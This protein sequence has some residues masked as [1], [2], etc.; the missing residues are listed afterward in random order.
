[1]L[2]R[3][4][5]HTFIP[6]LLPGNPVVIDLGANK[7][8]FSLPMQKRGCRVLAIEPVPELAAALRT[9]GVTV[10]E[11]A[12]TGSGGESIELT[13][14]LGRDA[15]M[16]GSVM[17]LG[18]VGKMLTESSTR[19]TVRVP[20]M[21]LEGAI[22]RAAGADLVKVDIEGAELDVLL[23]A[24]PET[25]LRIGQLAVEFHDFWYEQL[26][27]RTEQVKRRLQGLGF[28]MIRFTPNNK[29]VLFVNPR[30]RLSPLKRFW[31]AHVLRNVNG[32]G[33][34]MLIVLRRLG[35]MAQPASA[36]PRPTRQPTS[37]T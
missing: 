18:V 5:Q 13:Y 26:V 11:A 17:G 31:I 36:T 7:G 8:E 30:H 22:A 9:K 21:T 10:H 23:G 24:S 25:L 12:L 14:D 32:A 15:D 27:E 4:S 16:T 37:G 3:V 19:R 29:D 20:T 2:D 28:D 33:R 34:A 35:L 6:G 1:M